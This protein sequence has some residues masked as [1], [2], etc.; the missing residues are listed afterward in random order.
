MFLP[1]LVCSYPHLYVP[2]MTVNSLADV[3]DWAVRLAHGLAGNPVWVESR[4]VAAAALP[5]D[6]LMASFLFHCRLFEGTTVAGIGP[7]G[8]AV[9]GPISRASAFLKTFVRS[10]NC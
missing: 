4:A 5:I 9:S 2:T 1:S 7:M 8:W 10:R 6:E 3:G